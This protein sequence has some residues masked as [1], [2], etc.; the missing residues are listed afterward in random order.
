MIKVYE[1]QIEFLK[2]YEQH[3]LDDEIRY[4][5]ILGITKRNKDVS[6]M[7]SSEIENRFVVGVLAG[8][9]LLLAS[10]TLN[11]DVYSDLVKYMENED[12]PGIIG[13]REYC[14]IYHKKYQEISNKEMHIFM[15]QR[16]YSCTKVN[17]Q[18]EK[19]GSVR[20]ANENDV[21]KLTDW[22][23]KFTRDVQEATSPEQAK[24]I[25]EHQIK[26]KRLYV[27][28]VNNKVVSMA[29]RSRSL[30]ITESVGF[31]YTPVEFRRNGYGSIVTA[32]VTKKVLSD[33]KVA[34]LYT[35]LSNPTSN[36]IYMKI[37]YKPY[38]DSVM[39]NK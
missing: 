15:N 35:D 39:L 4:S 21:N 14:D 31:V 18:N 1:D 26:A 22:A 27:L 8:K 36:S 16:I 17:K 13:T 38:C 37:G 32:A 7:I 10:N 9:N 3:F 6:Q 20:L 24:I 12:Y 2:K 11:E 25:I 23:Y 34:T 30:S 5:L 19:T 33:G 29:A 28:E